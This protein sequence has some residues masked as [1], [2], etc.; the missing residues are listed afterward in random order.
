MAWSGTI[1]GE[2]LARWIDR[3]QKR[4]HLLGGHCEVTSAAG[5]GTC[6][7]LSI[8]VRLEKET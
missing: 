4:L 1:G 3:M 2:R 8:P 5:A 6:V 7:T